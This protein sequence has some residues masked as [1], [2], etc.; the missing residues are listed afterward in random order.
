MKQ[1]EPVIVLWIRCRRLSVCVAVAATQ[2]VEREWLLSG[3]E[4]ECRPIERVSSRAQYEQYRSSCIHI[5]PPS[6]YAV[7]CSSY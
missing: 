5:S 2:R 3:D 6:F 1:I 7:S 4:R